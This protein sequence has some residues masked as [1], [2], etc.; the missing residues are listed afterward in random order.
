MRCPITY[1]VIKDSGKRYSQKGLQLLSKNIKDLKDFS[2]PRHAQ[3]KQ[4]QVMME[5]LRTHEIQPKLKVS[6]N[7]TKEIFEIIEKGSTFILKPPSLL[8]PSLPENEDLTMRLA[9]SAGLDVPLH[10]LVYNTDGLFSFWS[11]RF[12]RPSLKSPI[13]LQ[14]CTQNF[15]Q[16]AETTQKQTDQNSLEN[17]VRIIEKHTTFP[18][19]EKEKLFCQVIFNFLVGNTNMHLKNISLITK[20]QVV[21]LSPAY[22]LMNTAIL[23]EIKDDEEMALSL[24]GK[25]H[26]LHS[27]DFINYF[28]ID[29]LGIHP[30]RIK[31]MVKN[32]ILAT[33]KWPEIIDVSFLPTPTKGVYSGLINKRLNQLLR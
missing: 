16:L 25:K 4:A 5:K 30:A 21:K 32:I 29:C 12:D 13:R 18:L 28:A 10:G 11:R 23:R 1:E 3:I 15:T 9:K 33:K 24:N 19:L 8:Y 31:K 20:N 22:N 17:V 7:P 26:M 6:L 14:L 2:Y 27:H